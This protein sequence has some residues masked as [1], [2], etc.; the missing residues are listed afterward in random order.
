MPRAPYLVQHP[1]CPR[2]I[3]HFNLDDHVW[4]K[5]V[6]NLHNSTALIDATRLFINTLHRKA[7]T[8]LDEKG[9]IQKQLDAIAMERQ[10]VITQAR[11]GKITDEDMDQQLG[12]LS[13]QELDL[14]Q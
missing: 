14:K 2:T 9:N 12:A 6:E 7:E 11:K 3:G 4:E 10:W 1:D 13:I 5:V 8:N